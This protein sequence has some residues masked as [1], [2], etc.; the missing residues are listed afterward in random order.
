MPWR[1]P[2]SR[3][4]PLPAPIA[5]ILA[6]C[7]GRPG[8]SARCRTWDITPSGNRVSLRL[9]PQAARTAGPHKGADA[10]ANQSREAHHSAPSHH[11]PRGASLRMQ[12][13]PTRPQVA[14][15]ESTE[16]C[17]VCLIALDLLFWSPRSDSNRRPSD[18]ESDRNLPTGPA[19]THPGCSG[20]GPIPSRPVLYRLVVTPGLPE[21]LPAV[22]PGAG[23]LVL[24]WNVDHPIAIGRSECCR[25]PFGARRDG[26][27]A[28]R[29]QVIT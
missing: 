5:C 13:R 7:Y 26:A 11:S 19:Q 17:S 2:T 20:T 24:I 21:R 18:Y 27:G 4:G 23:E 25:P 28:T 15:A 22:L 3:R 29:R 10:P 8:S 14:T 12:R 9:P 1:N 16:I 6:A